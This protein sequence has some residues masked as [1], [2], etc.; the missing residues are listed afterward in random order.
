MKPTQRHQLVQLDQAIAHLLGERARLL[1]GV[2]AD[3][4]GRGAALDDL[5]RRNHG[6]FAAETLRE[7]FAL[8]DR[9]CLDA[10]R[11]PAPFRAPTLGGRP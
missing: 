4:P 3:D 5:A 2:P 1:Q 9:G 7:V 11:G 8:I 10:T 6:P